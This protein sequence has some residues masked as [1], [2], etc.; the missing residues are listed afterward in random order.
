MLTEQQ[1]AEFDRNGFLNSG[2]A[3]NDAEVEELRGELTRVLRDK[4]RTDVSQPVRIVNLAGKPETPVWQVVNIFDASDAFRRVMHKKKIVEEIAQLTRANELRIWHDQIQYKPAEE[5]GVNMWHQDSPLWAPL[6]PKEEQV[7][8]WIALDDVDTSNGCMSMVPGSH[9]W[10]V[11]MPYLGT[12]KDF[13]SLPTEY[14]GHKIEVKLCPVKKGHVHYHH[15]LTWHASH[16]NNSGRPRRAIA[17]HYMTERTVYVP[18][19]FHPMSQFIPV[20]EGEKIQGDRFPVVW[21]KESR[22]AVEV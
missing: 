13:N 17:Y 20:K 21:K 1:V 12:L 3:L 5:G 16:A 18:D 14:K 9:K 6:T 8:A 19:N 22:V 2:A 7:S 11:E 4:D 10:G 15:A